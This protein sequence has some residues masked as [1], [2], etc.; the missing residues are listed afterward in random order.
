MNAKDLP[1]QK[2]VWA[3]RLRRVRESQARTDT[4]D[5]RRPSRDPGER[6]FLA[7]RGLLGRFPED[8]ALPHSSIVRHRKPPVTGLS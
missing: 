5:M 6:A 3:E 8:P 7:A 4:A 1:D 2:A